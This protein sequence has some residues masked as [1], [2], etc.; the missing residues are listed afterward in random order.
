MMCR[1]VIINSGIKRVVI[2]DTRDEYR[3]INVADWIENDDSLPEEYK[4][5]R[6][7]GCGA[8]AHT[9]GCACCGEG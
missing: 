2:R 6:D 8:H 3:E 7:G 1:R 9:H 4:A 5:E